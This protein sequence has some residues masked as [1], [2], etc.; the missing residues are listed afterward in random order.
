V[1]GDRVSLAPHA[2]QSPRCVGDAP[3]V[4]R[5]ITMRSETSYPASERVARLLARLAWPPTSQSSRTGPPPVLARPRRS[6]N[7]YIL[8]YIPRRRDP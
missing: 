1:H 6:T 4:P 7:L 2:C 8:M 5:S 3:S